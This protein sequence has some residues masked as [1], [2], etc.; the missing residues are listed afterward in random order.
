M[1]VYVYIKSF[2]VFFKKKEKK[3]KKCTA[4]GT[5]EAK[6]LITHIGIARSIGGFIWKLFTGKR[7]KGIYS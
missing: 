2:S 1:F 7:K 6:I 5:F 4:G 3:E